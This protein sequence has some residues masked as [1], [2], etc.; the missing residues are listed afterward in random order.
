LPITRPV[1]ETCWKKTYLMPSDSIRR[2]SSS[3]R[4]RRPG[5]L[6]ASSSV[7]GGGAMRGLAVTVATGA[8]ERRGGFERD[9]AVAVDVHLL[10]LLVSVPPALRWAAAGRLY[11]GVE[12]IGTGG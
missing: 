12:Q 7:A 1:I 6:R 9:A 10:S 3:I 11:R 2:V 5:T 4:S 8:A